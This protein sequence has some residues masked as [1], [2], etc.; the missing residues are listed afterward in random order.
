MAKRKAN[1]NLLRFAL[2]A[3]VVMAILGLMLNYLF[4]KPA[5]WRGVN[6]QMLQTSMQSALSHM[7]WQWQNK[8]R[9]SILVFTPENSSGGY[10]ITMNDLGIPVISANEQGCKT[11][12]PWLITQDVLRKQI[13]VSMEV[14]DANNQESLIC[15]FQ[16][17]QYI[18]QYHVVSGQ[19]HTK[20]L[21]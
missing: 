19:L 10:E 13:K 2:V 6:G 9:P 20:I 5:K 16:Y 15:K 11:L 8:G 18:Y 17:Q 21:E 3:C 4:I 14:I 1:V 12:M 7:Y